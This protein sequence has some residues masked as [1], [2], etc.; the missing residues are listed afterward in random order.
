MSVEGVCNLVC[1]VE[2]DEDGIC[3]GGTEGALG[4]TTGVCNPMGGGKED[5]DGI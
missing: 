1:G 3:E 5:E 2:E 4:A